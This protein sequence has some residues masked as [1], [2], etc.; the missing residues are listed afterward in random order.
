V[1]VLFKVAEDDR[2]EAIEEG[3]LFDLIF[4]PN[5]DDK[6]DTPCTGCKTVDGGLL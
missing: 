6:D 2:G 3:E 5:N 1:R 4:S